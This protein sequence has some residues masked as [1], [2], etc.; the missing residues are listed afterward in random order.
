MF[1]LFIV[2]LSFSSSL[3]TKCLF[4]S[5]EPC[6]G[7]PIITDLNPVEL[8]Y[9]A[10]IFSL[11]KSTGSCNVLS[12]KMC[13]PKETKDINVKAL[14]MITHKN[15]AKAM[16]EHVSCDCKCKFDSTICNSNQI[17]N[18][19]TCQLSYMQKRL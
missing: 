1:S 14:N 9:Y 2:L 11:N 15:E 3:A 10:F 17:W 6:M 5:D 19:K 4:L 12:P 18:N 8:K 7:R 16:A 13:V